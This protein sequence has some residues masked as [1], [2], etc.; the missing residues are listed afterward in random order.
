MTD[1]DKL[2]QER[3]ETHGKWADV[4]AMGA[5]LFSAYLGIPISSAD[6]GVLMQFSKNAR[7]KHGTFNI[8]DYKDNLGYA[9]LVYEDI[10]DSTTRGVKRD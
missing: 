9:T 3:E 2:L 5:K 6:Y 1:I 4:A 8:D 10:V 7:M